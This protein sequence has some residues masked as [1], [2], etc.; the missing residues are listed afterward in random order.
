MAVALVRIVDSCRM[1][2]M[3]VV[4]M[5]SMM[6]VRMVEFENYFEVNVYIYTHMFFEPEQLNSYIIFPPFFNHSI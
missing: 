6:V 2:S 3:M 4:R 1:V 5:V